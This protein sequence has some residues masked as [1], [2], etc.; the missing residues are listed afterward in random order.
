M[1]IVLK[2]TNNL[3][4]K[5]V[6]H[7]EEAASRDD[8]DL[9]LYTADSLLKDVNLALR[10]MNLGRVEY[11]DKNLYVT[12]LGVYVEVRLIDKYV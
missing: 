7:I 9:I 3:E 5:I 11:G 4:R 8:S 10:G 2:N 6:K 12:N 1:Q